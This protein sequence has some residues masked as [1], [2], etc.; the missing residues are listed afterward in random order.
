MP[1]LSCNKVRRYITFNYFL[2]V[3]MLITVLLKKAIINLYLLS[4]YL[5][6]SNTQNLRQH[7]LP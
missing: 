2:I 4:D 3:L 6:Q 7:Y 5:H 1:E